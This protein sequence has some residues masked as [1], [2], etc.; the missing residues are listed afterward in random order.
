MRLRRGGRIG[1]IFQDPSTSLNPVMRVGEQI[2]ETIV[3]HTVLRGARARS[4]A[5][6]WLQL[7]GIPDPERQIDSFPFQLSGGQKQR[8]MIAIALAAEPKLLIADEPTTALDVTIQAQIL[9]LLSELQQRLSMA[10]LLITHDLAVVARMA[11]RVALMYAGQIVETADANEFFRAPRHPYAQQLLAALPERG[12]RDRPLSSIAG[13][14]PP[15]TLEFKGCRF[16]ERCLTAQPECAVTRPELIETG[17]GHLVRCVLYRQG[18]GRPVTPLLSQL[19]V[20]TAAATA[21]PGTRKAL[22][23]VLLE[24]RDL[25]VYF[26]IRHG[27]LRRVRSYVRAVDGISFSLAA[28]S[29]LALVGESGCGK[30]TTGK[31]ILQLLR[32]QSQISGEILLDGSDLRSANGKRL[33]AIRRRAQIIFQDP[34]ASLDPRMRIGEI[35]EEGLVVLRPE[36]DQTTRGQQV[37]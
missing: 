28:S 5:I 10:I 9:D 31:A 21:D 4:K 27:V 19:D 37:R 25:K 33:R 17:A 16:V 23:P 15:L 14:V 35:L 1:M 11:H 24:V 32:A 36:L 2:I 13:S 20:G 3:A 30:T 12:Q 18:Y 26:P 22:T 34:F 29:T 7:V 6:E 8:V